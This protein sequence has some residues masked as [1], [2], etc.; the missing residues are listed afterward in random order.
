MK[1]KDLKTKQDL[2]LHIIKLAFLSAGAYQ[3]NF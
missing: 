3:D 1:F 2:R